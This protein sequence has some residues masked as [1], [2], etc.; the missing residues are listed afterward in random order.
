MNLVIWILV[1]WCLTKFGCWL[2]G[3]SPLLFW[4]YAGFVAYA[5]CTYFYQEGLIPILKKV[6]EV[7][8][9]KAHG[10]IKGIWTSDT[11]ARVTMFGFN[12]TLGTTMFGQRRWRLY[13]LE[14][15]EQIGRA[16]C[17]DRV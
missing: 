2:L 5:L 9:R 10:D 3:L 4:P 17:R 14:N 15:Y 8:E 12:F 1:L 16:S 13:W 11:V 7:D 6:R